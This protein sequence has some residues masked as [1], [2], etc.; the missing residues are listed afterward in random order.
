[1]LAHLHLEANMP[2]PNISAAQSR[3]AEIRREM[4]V[5]ADDICSSAPY[6]FGFLQE[7]SNAPVRSAMGALMLLWPLTAAAL[8]DQ[9]PSPVTG[10]C[11]QCFDVISEV[12]GIRQATV[13]RQWALSSSD[14]YMWAD[15]FAGGQYA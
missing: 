10:F 13:L 12:M 6:I 9:H 7:R 1:M 5:L 4:R 14:K 15:S 2:G 11:F 8:A 3:C